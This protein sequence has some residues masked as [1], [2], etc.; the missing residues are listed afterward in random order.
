[1]YSQNVG[2]R[3]F[4]TSI[5]IAL[6]SV[7]LATMVT[8]CNRQTTETGGSR[9]PRIAFVMKTLNHPF[10]LDM[11]RGAEEAAS[12]LD[13][14]LV[15]QAAEREL[16]VEKQTQIIENLIQTGIQALCVTPSGSKEIA[17]VLG[18]ATAANIPIVVADTRL[19]TA[20]ATAANVKFGTFVG[21][22]NYEGGRIA[23]QFMVQS[24][25]GQANVAI[26]EGI[27]GHETGDSRLRGFRDAVASSPGIKIVASQP[28]N[29]ERD[30]GF[31]VFQNMLQAHPEIDALFAASDLMALGAVEAIA[32][33]N[34][35]GKVRVI[36]FDALDD[37]RKAIDAGRMVGSV[38]QSPRD[39]GRISVESAYKLLR[40]ESVPA[41]QKVPITLVSKSP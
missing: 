31:T 3:R 2:R 20:A 41:D 13:V 25:G 6:A 24:T 17:S 39:M 29:W 21:S 15:V 36:G 27:P 10:F 8:A 35:T 33:A 16:D 26:L 32:A 11:K 40:G 12:R 14:E 1:M 5:A 7:A 19:D 38:A 34:R 9:R 18:K 37:A 30:Q 23:G 28:A 4:V 22:D